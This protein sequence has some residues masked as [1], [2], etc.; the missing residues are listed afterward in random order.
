LA[1]L[2]VVLARVVG[3]GDV[4]RL[5]TTCDEIAMPTDGEIIGAHPVGTSVG[6]GRTRIRT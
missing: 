6:G 1:L 4:V 2:R 3:S 5:A